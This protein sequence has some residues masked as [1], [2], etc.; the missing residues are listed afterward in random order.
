MLTGFIKAFWTICTFNSAPQNLP[1][2][3]T[4][5]G[6]TAVGYFAVSLMIAALQLGGAHAFPAALLDVVLLS[7]LTRAVLWV[8][9]FGER[10]V[11]T[12]TALTGTG[13]LLG[14]V[15]V[16]VV[17]WHQRAQASGSDASLPALMLLAWMAWDLAVIAYILRHALSTVFYV[18]AALALVYAYIAYRLTTVLFY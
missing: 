12:L 17:A 8:R 5:L 1:A 14:L 6:I 11:Q 18:G 16:P 10:F 4:L 15:A 3:W 9:M 7:A 13:A 2:S